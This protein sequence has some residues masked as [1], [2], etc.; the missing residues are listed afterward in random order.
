VRGTCADSAHGGAQS[1]AH[2]GAMTVASGEVVGCRCVAES[3][4]RVVCTCVAEGGGE[5]SVSVAAEPEYGYRLVVAG[6]GG[7]K[8]TVRTERLGAIKVLE[9]LE[10][11]G[12][13]DPESLVRRVEELFREAKRR[14]RVTCKMKNAAPPVIACQVEGESFTLKRV[15]GEWYLVEPY[16]KRIGQLSLSAVAEVAEKFFVSAEQLYATLAEEIG[17]THPSA[18]RVEYFHPAHDYVEGLGP[19]LGVKYACEDMECLGYVYVKDGRLQLADA[20]APVRD[21]DAKVVYRP[22]VSSPLNVT[23]VRVHIPDF[24]DVLEAYRE[25][26]TFPDVAREVETHIRSR[27]TASD[28]DIKFA[29]VFVVASHFFPI[30]TYHPALVLGKPGFGTGG[31]TAAKVLATLMPRPAFFVDPSWAVLFR[32]AHVFRPTFVIDEVILDLGS[33]TLQ[34]IKLYLIARFDYDLTVPRADEGGA[35]L[36]TFSVYSNSIII[37]PQGL[38]ANL[39]TVRRSPRITLYPDPNRREIVSIEKELRRPEVRRLA[40]RLYA[41][42]LRYAAELKAEYEKVAK[43]SPCH[44]SVLQ[45]FGLLLLVARRMGQEYLDAVAAKIR[46]WTDEVGVMHAVGDPTKQVLAKVLEDIEHLEEYVRARLSPETGWL[47]PESVGGAEPP[48]PW[49]ADIEG[50]QVILW[51]SLESWRKYLQRV[52]G[53]LRQVSRRKETGEEVEWVETRVKDLGPAL[54]RTAFASLLRPY[55]SHVMRRDRR[56]HLRVVFTSLDDIAKAREDL[57]RA[58]PES[59]FGTCPPAPSAGETSRAQ[60]LQ[61]PSAERAQD[62]RT[63]SATPRAGA[64]RSPGGG[65]GD[66]K[67][68]ESGESRKEGRLGENTGDELRSVTVEEVLKAVEELLSRNEHVSTVGEDEKA[69]E[70]LENFIATHRPEGPAVSVGAEPQNAQPPRRRG[71]VEKKSKDE[72]LKEIEE[73]LKKYEKMSGHD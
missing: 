42:F 71:V 24:V 55:L 68:S 1:V 52:L 67:N 57:R 7:E 70:E 29:T 8:T 19:V 9:T 15:G 31:T 4:R 44:G 5:V 30:A 6:Q 56:R 28:T 50:G 26:P 32:A 60:E 11:M 72:I 69:K 12:V 20:S 34:H 73:L 45:S 51:T 27:V 62:L 16:V 41:L 23:G 54:S 14:A 43:I 18:W 2:G 22:A 66:M 39:A 38:V 25:A 61:T 17:E 64:V 49:R 40:A 21:E 59:N 33:E 65:G 13:P 36:D 37:D 58:I 53:E 10:E 63:P 47:T 35:R 48:K 46:E 3:R